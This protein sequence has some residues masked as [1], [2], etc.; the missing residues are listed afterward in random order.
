MAGPI[1]RRDR[2]R[3]TAD[4]QTPPVISAFTAWAEARWPI[5]EKAKSNGDGRTNGGKADFRNTCLMED[6][7]AAL[8][9]LPCDYE[10]EAWVKLGMAY[11][12]GGGSYAVF[13]EW[14]RQ[15]RQYRSDSYVA[16]Q[17]RSFANSHSVTVATLFAEVF[18]RFPGWKKP[19]E[20]GADYTGP[21]EDD[22][23]SEPDD[24]ADSASRTRR[25]RCL[26]NLVQREPYPLEALGSLQ[27]V[28]EGIAKAVGVRSQDWPR[29]A[30]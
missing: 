21:A 5:P 25:S 17:W 30:S 28:V 19:T 4:H 15:H 18:E 2:D 10:R 3:R 27:G 12:A 8:K 16:G 20:R 24:E 11:R 13:L 29:K 1:P 9:A 14:S 7:E 22:W 26:L 6:V 23:D